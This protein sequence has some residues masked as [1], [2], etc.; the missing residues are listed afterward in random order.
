MKV[1]KMHK[2]RFRPCWCF[3]PTSVARDSKATNLFDFNIYKNQLILSDKIGKSCLPTKL[4]EIIY[5][6]GISAAKKQLVGEKHQQ[7]RKCY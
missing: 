1:G 5:E 2:W 7:G 3:S 6:K 4:E